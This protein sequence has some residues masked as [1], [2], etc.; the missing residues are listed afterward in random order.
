[1]FRIYLE[2]KEAVSVTEAGHLY[3]VLRDEG[4]DATNGDLVISATSGGQLEVTAG[5]QIQGTDDEYDVVNGE[6]DTSDRGQLRDENGNL[7]PIDVRI[8]GGAAAWND[9]VAFANE[10]ARAATV[11]T[12][13]AT[14]RPRTPT[15]SFLRPAPRGL[16]LREIP[17]DH[18][19]SHDFP[20]LGTLLGSDSGPSPEV[21]AANQNLT[22]GVALLGGDNVDDVLI[23]TPLADFFLGEQQPSPDSLSDTVSYA[24][25]D[26]GVEG[27]VGGAPIFGGAPLSRVGGRRP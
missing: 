23:G 9:M 8:L 2:H 21:I 14:T 27:Q 6:V 13:R 16:D 24:T 11:T 7:V 20:G 10:I 12:C 18:D 19:Y 1:M 15:P 5:D 22:E 3:L 26:A 4:A 17:I 25:S